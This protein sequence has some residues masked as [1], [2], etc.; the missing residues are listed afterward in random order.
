MRKRHLLAALAGGAAAAAWAATVAPGAWV[1]LLDTPAAP[2]PLA[3]RGLLNGLALAGTRIVAVGQRGHILLSD[4][5]GTVW[6][7]AAVP[8]SSDLVAVHFP[9]AQLGWAVGHDG[10][11][12]HSEDAGRSWKRQR[13][14]RPDAADVPLLDVWFE[15][16]R[17]GW[18]VGAFGLVLRTTDAGRSWD[19]PQDAAENPKSL[20]IYAVRGI[21]G[22]LYMAGEQGLLLRREAASGRFK[23]LASPYAGTLFGLAGDARAVVGFGL[24]GNVVRS[25]DAGA[26]WQGLNTGVPVGLTAGTTDARGRI[27]IAS[28]AG[29]L[30]ASGDGGASFQPVRVEKLVPA[31]AVLVAGGQLVVAGPRGVQR[32]ALP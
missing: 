13:D 15:D 24:R 9:T 31:A 19:A 18:A 6:Q 30:L 26:T 3:P 5:G 21:G 27:V 12:L 14:G 17:T 32:V 8:V 22:E 16:G 28:Q 20:H 23:A 4:D 29:H 1:D 25:T 11:I 10:V 2:S 7:Q